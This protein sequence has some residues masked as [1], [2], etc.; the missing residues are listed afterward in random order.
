M[1]AEQVSIEPDYTSKPHHTYAHC[2]VSR[3]VYRRNQNPVNPQRGINHT[4]ADREDGLVTT[5]SSVVFKSNTAYGFHVDDSRIYR[6]REQALAQLTRD[7]EIGSG[8]REVLTRALGM[9]SHLEVDFFRDPLA[10]GAR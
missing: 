6:W 8:D 1:Q 4:G 2:P 5:F 10:R 7:H 9:D 3:L